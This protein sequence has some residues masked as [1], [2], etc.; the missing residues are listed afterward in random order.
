[1]SVDNSFIAEILA[2]PDDVD[3]R[4]IYADW[5]EDHGD[6]RGELIRLREELRNRSPIDPRYWDAKER[7][8]ELRWQTNERW[9][10]RLG[11]DCAYRPLFAQRPADRAST[12]RAIEEFIELWHQPLDR[13]CG[14]TEQE[15]AAA[16]QRLRIRLP[17]ALREWYL[18]A[19]KRSSE[20]DVISSVYRAAVGRYPIFLPLE[21]LYLDGG[22][23]VCAVCQPREI[24]TIHL[25][26]MHRADPPIG[27]VSPQNR[28][29][30]RAAISV[31]MFAAQSLFLAIRCLR[32]LASATSSAPVHSSRLLDAGFR[33]SA[34]AKSHGYL[35]SVT[36][37]EALDAFALQIGEEGIVH[38]AA[39]SAD[40]W[41]RVPADLQRS[42]R[43]SR[44]E[45]LVE[46]LE[47]AM[48]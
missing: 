2:Q 47:R 29:L 12:W 21:D 9:L 36:I 6:P 16:E 4:L 11:Y 48:R 41:A 38:L 30:R 15:I 26:H 19:G 28:T 33:Q 44:M 37:Y 42:M 43:R 23:L 31:S 3:R 46:D 34:I 8:Q 10:K 13:E 35:H 20:W 1:M 24:L 22:S 25:R 17:A 39:R 5:L 18:L 45:A 27:F 40:V 32:G 14:N 7:F